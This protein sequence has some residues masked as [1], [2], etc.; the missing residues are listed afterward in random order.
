M[1]SRLHLFR[2]EFTRPRRA[3]RNQ[4]YWFANKTAGVRYWRWI[5]LSELDDKITR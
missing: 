1:E 4:T 2:K 5:E 3:I